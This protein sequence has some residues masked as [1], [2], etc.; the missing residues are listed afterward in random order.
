[1]RNGEN[2]IELALVCIN[3]RLEEGDH[4]AK[5][6]KQLLVFA[7]NEPL[8]VEALSCRKW[9]IQSGPDRLQMEN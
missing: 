2:S 7:K 9:P 4:L 5:R 3:G 1:V 8:Y 6:I